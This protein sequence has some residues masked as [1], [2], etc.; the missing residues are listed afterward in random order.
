MSDQY[1]QSGDTACFRL[2]DKPD[3]HMRQNV[4]PPQQDFNA[5]RW[6]PMPC[7]SQVKEPNPEPPLSMV[8]AWARWHDE[9]TMMTADE[10]AAEGARNYQRLVNLEAAAVLAVAIGVDEAEAITR[11]IEQWQKLD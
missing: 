4:W 11:E 6:Y 7:T 3:W 10:R 2:M 8:E 5:P 9:R 1:S